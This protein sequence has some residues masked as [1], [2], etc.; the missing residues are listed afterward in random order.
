MEA[1]KDRYT[2]YVNAPP[3]DE[4]SGGARSL[5]LL[6]HYLNST[7]FRARML[8]KHPTTVPE[9]L[10]AP[11][12]SD[13][14]GARI[15]EPDS[16]AVVVYPEII[17]GNRLGGR[18]VIRY[19]LNRPGIITPDRTGSYGR[20]DFIITF[21]K[22]HVPEGRQY[23]DLF[24][25]LVDRRHYHLGSGSGTR[26]GFVVCSKRAP[27]QPI[28]LPKWATPLTLVVPSQPRTHAQLGNLYRSSRALIAYERSSVIYEALSCGCPVIGISSTVFNKDTYQAR[29]GGAGMTWG[30]DEAELARATA[31]VGRFVEVYQQIESDFPRR[32][33]DVFLQILG[34]CAERSTS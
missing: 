25:P 16:E 6:C 1:L 5:F 31:E 7:G 29:F 20:D 28:V 34:M 10:L 11:I 23:F 22:N 32:V 21:D 18:H 8:C 4:R 33:E 19:L 27:E 14:G 2:I 17:S 3:Y 15:A 12:T 13:E 30:F 26:E 24:M 9:H